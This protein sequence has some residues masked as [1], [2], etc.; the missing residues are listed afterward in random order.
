MSTIKRGSY[1]T[2]FQYTDY[3][4]FL[5]DTLAYLLDEGRKLSYRS[6][7]DAVGIKSTGHFTLVLQGKANISIPLAMKLARFLKLK[8][9]ESDYFQAL[10]LFNQAKKHA[11]KRDYFVKMMSFKESSIRLVS[12][13]QY[14]YYDK[15]YHAVIRAL[16]EIVPVKDDFSV[17]AKMV[18][19]PVSADEVRKSIELMVTLQ[20]VKK[21]DLG[22]FR[23]A[24]AI[25]DSGPAIGSLAVTNYAMNMLELG[26]QA[27]DRFPLE[28]RIFSWA[29]L[30]VSEKGY[31]QVVQEL[32]EF[33]RKVYEIAKNDANANRIYQV[34][35]QAFPVSKPHDEEDRR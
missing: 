33:R 34:N 2:V 16:L 15:W 24:E 32:R 14:E 3:R 19:P 10:V 8:K 26:K 25:I 1:P 30:G 12:A 11:D 29:T 22:N 17:I 5:L 6:I 21:D 27:F 31:E 4:K 20:L 23:P 13:D 7:C 28:E 9:R 18:D 35:I